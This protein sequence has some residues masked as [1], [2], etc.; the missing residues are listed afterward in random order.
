[1]CSVLGARNYQL[2]DDVLSEMKEIH[3]VYSQDVNGTRCRPKH[4]KRSQIPIM[5]TDYTNH[6]QPGAQSC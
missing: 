5:L 1:M 4:K 3:R 2:I 6:R